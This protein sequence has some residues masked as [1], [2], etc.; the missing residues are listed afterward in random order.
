[1]TMTVEDLDKLSL[2][3][4]KL[5]AKAFADALDAGG[6]GLISPDTFRAIADGYSSHED[7]NYDNEYEE[8]KAMHEILDKVLLCG[9]YQS[10]Q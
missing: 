7:G 2:V 9:N 5:F 3:E 8:I 1:M 4:T 6:W 10:N